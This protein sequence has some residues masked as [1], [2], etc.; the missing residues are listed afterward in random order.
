L[1]SFSCVA[2][3]RSPTSRAQT[4]SIEQIYEG[5]GQLAASSVIGW[6]AEKTVLRPVDF[7]RLFQDRADA[8]RRYALELKLLITKENAVDF[9]HRL[10]R[11]HFA[12]H[13][14]LTAITHSDVNK[15]IHAAQSLGWLGDVR[16]LE[17]LIVALSDRDANVRGLAARSLGRLGDPK[18]VLPL[19]SLLNDRNHEVRLSAIWALG[20]L[21]DSSSVHSLTGLL[22]SRNKEIRLEVIQALGRIG[23]VQVVKSLA[24]ALKNSDQE[25]AAQAANALRRMRTPEAREAL[26]A[27]DSDQRKLWWKFRQ[28]KQY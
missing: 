11:D 10:V 16:A 22:E 21:H 13:F 15:R 7:E 9:V 3:L 8:F 14:G 23:D 1:I 17:P 2:T 26:E 28:G 18:A 24:S 25:I 20:M 5:L 4:F 6:A 12:L 27:W 19:V